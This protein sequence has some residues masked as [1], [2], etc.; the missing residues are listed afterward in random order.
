MTLKGDQRELKKIVQKN[1]I[2]KNVRLL[3]ENKTQ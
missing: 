1:E 3:L 2:I